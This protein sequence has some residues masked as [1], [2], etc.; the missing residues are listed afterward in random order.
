MTTSHTSRR[1]DEPLLSVRDLSVTFGIKHATPFRAVDGLSFDVRPGQT[2]GLVG[3]SGCG[4]SVTSLAIMGLL[5]DRGNQVSGTVTYGG[6]D[7]LSL[8]DKEMRGKRGKDI[9]MIFQDPLSS[10]NP[11]VPI[12][13][14]VTEVLERHKGMSKKEAM[15]HAREMLRKVGI[16]DPDRRLKDY[17]HQ[18]SGGMRQRVALARALAQ[19]RPLL[20]M[21]EPF[22]ALDAITR[23]LLHGELERVWRQTGRTVVFVTHN[24]AEAV[25]LGQRVLLLSS[26]PGRVVAEWDVP[27]AARHDAPAA[28]ALTAA[29]T[30]R[31]GQEIRRHAH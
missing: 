31:L 29:I 15:P 22:A 7:L 27:A 4:K 28:A 30:A 9:S 20:L 26:R 19:D 6:E 23:D 1:S 25:R 21:D 13:R 12:G 11:V 18:L 14:Q 8:S 5:P 17:P 3:E 2:V 16:P 10:L 24:V